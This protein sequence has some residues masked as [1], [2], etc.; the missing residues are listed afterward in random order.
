MAKIIPITTIKTKTKIVNVSSDDVT[1]ERLSYDLP[2]IVVDQDDTPSV[3]PSVD[4][5]TQQLSESVIAALLANALENPEP[6][7]EEI[8]ISVT[9]TTNESVIAPVESPSIIT[10]ANVMLPSSSDEILVQGTVNAYGES[11][12]SNDNWTNPSNVLGDTTSTA[13]TL[14]AASSGFAGSTSNITTGTIVVDIPD[15]T[16]KELNVVSASLNIENEADT[17]GLP[18]GGSFDVDF[19]YSTNGVDW[20]LIESVTANKTKAITNVDVTSILTTD[21]DTLQ[22]RATGSVE[23][24]TGIGAERTVSFF[25]CWLNLVADKTY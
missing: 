18:L 22:F 8:L 7:T 11:V 13:T 3:I 14:S 12:S 10:E 17:S 15:S 1:N 2:E 24:G 20:T 19:E 21:F 16:I 6:I 23:S 5:T 4:E 9:Q 25:R